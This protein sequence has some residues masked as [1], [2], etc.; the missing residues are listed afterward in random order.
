M[1][2]AQKLIRGA[3][4]LLDW[5]ICIALL[6]ALLYG[7]YA[8]WDNF[9]IYR[10]T[11][12]DSQIMKYKPTPS[13]PSLSELQAINPDVCAWLTLD[14]TH[15]DYPVLHGTDNSRY[16]NTDFYG[17]YS[18]GGSIFL[19]YRNSADFTDSYSLLYGH[20]MDGG[21]MFGD[22][23]NFENET[24]FTQ[25]QT[26]T[27]ILNGKTFKLE[28]YAVLHE[29]AYQSPMFQNVGNA[30]KYAQRLEYIK[31]HAVQYREI[32]TTVNDQILAMSTCASATTNGRSILIAQMVEEND[33]GGQ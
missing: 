25:H 23:V 9:M 26:G 27:L 24:Y 10:N 33:A 29:D 18:L 28:I 7:G 5:L 31:Q 1:G 32:G 19:D 20:H 14:N 17:K 15:V 11:D 6:L 3:D 13:N 8:L 2:V 16:L 30:G 22:I 12:L 21:A 4:R